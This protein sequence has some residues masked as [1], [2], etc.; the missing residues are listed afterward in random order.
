VEDTV[1]S[2]VVINDIGCSSFL[3]SKSVVY[4]PADNLTNHHLPGSRILPVSA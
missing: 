2:I 4:L 3:N 1:E